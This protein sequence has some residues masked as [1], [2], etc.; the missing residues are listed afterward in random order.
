MMY[1]APKGRKVLECFDGAPQEVEYG[2]KFSDSPNAQERY[3]RSL[4]GFSRFLEEEAQRYRRSSCSRR[5][6]PSS[7]SFRSP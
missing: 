3:R 5:S 6:C 2:F 4:E 1:D 7:R